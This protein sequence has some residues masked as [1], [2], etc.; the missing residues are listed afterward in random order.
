MMRISLLFSTR[1]LVS[2]LGVF[3]LMTLLSMQSLSVLA[4]A[5]DRQAKPMIDDE[6]PQ[7]GLPTTTMAIGGQTY[8]LEV[9]ATPEQA[10]KG[11]MFRTSLPP[12]QGMLFL[13]QP[14]HPVK[15]WMKNTKIPLDMLFLSQGRVT[16]IQSAA[17]PC[18]ADPCAIYGPDTPVDMVVELPS[19]TAAKH[20]IIAGSR[21][22]VEWPVVAK[23]TA[24]QTAA[25][26]AGK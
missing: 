18:L 3:V 4:G 25:S 9:A 24:L 7:T 17:Q 5:G 1:K 26:S 16:F 6:A 20:K 21:V 2:L 11:L 15:F 14:A 23:R 8:H 13:F 12:R 19:G 22:H 10:E